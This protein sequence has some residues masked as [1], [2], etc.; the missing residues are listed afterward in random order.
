MVSGWLKLKGCLCFLLLLCSCTSDEKEIQIPLEISKENIHVSDDGLSSTVTV[1]TSK[2]WK[3]VNGV[4]W[5][6][7]SPMFGHGSKELSFKVFPNKLAEERKAVVYFST[8]TEKVEM[9]VTQSGI[10]P[11]IQTSFDRKTVHPSGEKFQISVLNVDSNWSVDIP[12]STQSWISLLSKEDNTAFLVAKLNNNGYKRTGELYFKDDK[13]GKIAEVVVNQDVFTSTVADKKWSAVATKQ[14]D[15]WYAT[16]EA[17]EVAE[18]VLLYQKDCGGWYKNIEMHQ[19]LT[20]QEKEAVKATKS[21]K[22]C[23]DNG[24]TT[25][26]LRFL[27]KMYKQIPDDKYRQAFIKGVDYIL[28]AQYDNGGWPQYFPLRGGYSDYITFN[29]NLVV[30]LLRLL[31]DVCQNQR[32]FTT[33]VENDVIIK[34][35]IAF[36]KGVDCILKCQIVDGEVK[37]FWCA[38]HDQVTLDPAVGRPHEFPSFSGMEGTEILKFLMEIDNPTIEIKE[39]V[40]SAVNWLETHKIPDKKVVDVKDLSG[41]TIDREIVDSPGEDMWGRFIQL[42]G[43][44]AQRVY[45]NLFNDVLNDRKGWITLDDGSRIIY[46]YKDNAEESYDPNK[47]YLPIYGIYDSSRPFLLYRF[48]YVYEDAPTYQDKNGYDV[49]V[50]LDAANR[51]SYQYVGNWPLNVLRKLYPEWRNKNGM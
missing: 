4:S 10:E 32:D 26:E 12:V 50:S 14:P 44:V 31:K 2:N 34:A 27:A 20:D 47:A 18:N 49:P 5:I 43:D 28:S 35:K 3:I 39:A 22:A 8:E 16:N 45:T 9:V 33:I 17:K 13:T 15:S 42:G 40:V 7:L 37:T 19:L 24:A 48:L 41:Q 21:E 38:Q 11:V 51:K 23:F 6:K 46:N 29:D 1:T 36:D 30:N 25:T